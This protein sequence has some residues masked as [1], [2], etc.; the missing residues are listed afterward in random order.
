MPQK[1]VVVLPVITREAIID[2]YGDLSRRI[3]DFAPT[4]AR[5]K[6]LKDEIRGWY[7][8]HPPDDTAVAVGESSTIYVGSREWRLE[9]TDIEALFNL[10]GVKRFLKFCTFPITQ[11][12]KVI[13]VKHSESV[14]TK[15]QSGLRTIKA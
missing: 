3:E 13:T 2:E 14:T 11:I 4:A 8:K 15:S 6:A 10:V 9:I 5:H 12:G 1:A 7:D